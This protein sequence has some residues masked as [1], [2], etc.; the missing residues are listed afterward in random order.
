ME[1]AA[2]TSGTKDSVTQDVKSECACV[3][4]VHMQHNVRTYSGRSCMRPVVIC[5]HLSDCGLFLGVGP[6]G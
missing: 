2:E 6:Q 1:S 4:F 5:L 3:L